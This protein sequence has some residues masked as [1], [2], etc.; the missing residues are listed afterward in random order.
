MRFDRLL[1][2]GWDLPV[3]ESSLLRGLGEDSK[4]LSVQL[5]RWVRSGRLIQI[6]R[7][8]YVLPRAH[9]RTRHPIDRVA[10]LVCRPSYVTAER[11]LHLHGLIPETVPVVVSATTARAAHY[12]TTVGSFEYRRVA[13]T[14]F[15]GFQEIEVG[16]G[17]A[18]VAVRE[19]ALLDLVATTP[20]EFTLDRIRGVRLQE[21]DSV[22]LDLVERWAEKSGKPRLGRF[23]QRLRT[24][25]SEDEGVEL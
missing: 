9:Q 21:L 22:D 18:L 25:A 7:G 4:S 10:N 1:E 8:V 23:A 12:D 19:K 16:G 6:R 5:H 11:A 20:G 14:W 17:T 13:Q 2:I 24:I 3:I 15:F